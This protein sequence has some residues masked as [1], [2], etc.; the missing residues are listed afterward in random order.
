MRRILTIGAY[1]FTEQTFAAALRHAGVDLFV[2][3]RQRRG[4][5]GAAHAFAN[6]SRLQALL[7]GLGIRYVHAQDLAPS[8]AVRDVQRQ[9]DRAEGTAKRQRAALSPAFVHAYTAHA[10][11]RFDAHAFLRDVV[12]DAQVVALFCV[13]GDP[14]AC[15]RSLVAERLGMDLNKEI[16]HLA[17]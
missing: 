5:R 15:H 6:R 3:L 11:S 10:L 1:G 2:D 14:R 13:E 7:A 12:G 17:P 8:T 16:L 4:V 9:L